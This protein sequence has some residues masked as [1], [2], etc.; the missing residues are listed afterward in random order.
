[1]ETDYESFETD[2]PRSSWGW[3]KG[4]GWCLLVLALLVAVFLFWNHSKGTSK[5]QQTLAELDRT[6][7]GWRLE[8]IEAAR[9][10][11]PDE[12]NS[13]RVV[14]A[15]A[16]LI[17]RGWP[18]Q[19]LTDRF[20]HLEPQEQLADDD[21]ARLRAELNRVRPALDVAGKLADMPRGRHRLHFARNPIETLLPDQG[22]SR[23]VARLLV[24][25]A[26]RQ[27]Q[28]GETKNALASCRT[29]STP[30]AR[31]AT[32]RFSFRN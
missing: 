16:D 25:E 21:F 10:E 7:P 8:D 28:Q 24:Y 26:M 23:D 3:L 22:K 6:E 17:P 14:V 32:N 18:T 29:H 4:I 20:T 13:A 5:L 19:E 31:W 1:M 12:E 30:P 2:K 15:A 9:A 11:I 27:S